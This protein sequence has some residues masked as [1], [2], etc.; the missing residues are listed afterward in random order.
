MSKGQMVCNTYKKNTLKD[1]K[2]VVVLSHYQGQILLN[3]HKNRTTWETQGGHIEPG[4][5]PE[6]AA[7]RELY[8]ESG[9]VEFDIHYLCDYRAEHP[10]THHGANG[11]VF[12][13]EIYTLGSIP[14]SEMAKVRSF[15]ELPDNLTYP[16]ITPILFQAIDQVL[17]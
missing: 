13:A 7:R 16:E 6:Q 11:A 12:V 4:E 15:P 1:Y 14:E 5:T 8:E 9:A 10:Q 2:Y 3:R 17:D